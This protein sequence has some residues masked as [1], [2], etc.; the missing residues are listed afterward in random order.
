MAW[1]KIIIFI[2]CFLTD[3]FHCSLQ[4]IRSAKKNGKSLKFLVVGDWGRKGLYNQSRVAVQMGRIGKELDID[5]VISTGDNFYKNGLN[6]TNDP[7]FEE[8]FSRIYTAK[9][10]LVPWYSVLGNHDYRGDALAQLNSSLRNRDPRWNCDRSFVLKYTICPRE[11]EKS[12]ECTLADLFFFD[13]NPYVD[14]Y[15]EPS[16]HRYDWR[17]IIPYRYDWR[18]ISPRQMYLKQQLQDLSVA[19]D[20]STATWKIVIGHHT[21]RS[22]GSHGDTE[23]LVQQLL[24]IIEAHGV[25]MY[26]NGHDHCLEHIS[27]LNSPLQFLTSGGGS[28]AW[29]GMKEGANTEGLQF[30][31]NGQGFMSVKVKAKNLQVAFHDVD[32]NTIHELDLSKENGHRH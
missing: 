19:L 15:W 18:G 21:I 32:G 7:S 27:S 11:S 24:P 3:E 29:R 23:E 9:S 4:N 14:M 6:G 22:V 5:F 8:C 12:Q 2:L 20:A 16:N 26:M 17:G 30:F 25:D 10:L 1:M 13:T 28:K 31:H